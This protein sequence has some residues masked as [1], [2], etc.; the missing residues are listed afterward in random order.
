MH[1][2]RLAACAGLVAILALAAG[3]G[4]PARP[5][6][7]ALNSGST[8]VVTPSS[9]PSVPASPAAPASADPGPSSG[10][11]SSADVC[12]L[13][14]L[15]VKLGSSQGAAGHILD[16]FTL[17]NTGA[18]PCRLDGY[19]ALTLLTAGGQTVPVTYSHGSD[20]AF[21]AR[22]PQP[23]KLAPGT[24]AS[25]SVGYPDVPSGSQGSCPNAAAV[26]VTPPGDA[27]SVSVHVAMSPCGTV[28]VSPVVTG[29][30]GA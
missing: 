13:A 21:Q 27:G 15:A 19:P 1:P 10:P 23:V 5:D 29:S 11:V 26:R 17:T 22:A 24:T 14:A 8:P 6:N 30:N 7:S 28:D 25:F 4:K 18:V 9:P 16:V 3:C 20:M 2:Q 12:R